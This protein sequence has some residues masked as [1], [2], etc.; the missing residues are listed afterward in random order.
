LEYLDT[1]DSDSDFILEGDTDDTCE[2][3]DVPHVA[4]PTAH[5]VSD[6]EKDNM[7]YE[8]YREILS[9]EQPLPLPFQLQELSGPKHMPPPDS[10][11]VAYFHLFFTEL[12]LTLMATKSNR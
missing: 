3:D 11:P 5:S 7:D 2:K 10:P 6:T 9:P 1:T 12:S 4:P 8:D